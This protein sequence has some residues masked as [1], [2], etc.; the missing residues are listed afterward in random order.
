[1]FR[2]RFVGLIASSASS[3]FINAY[4]DDDALKTNF[5]FKTF[6]VN[7]T[8]SEVLIDVSMLQGIVSECSLNYVAVFKGGYE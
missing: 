5:Q 2:A 3:L 8:V 4:V 6:G 1:M 7:S